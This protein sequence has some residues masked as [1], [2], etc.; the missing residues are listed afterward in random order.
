[1]TEQQTVSP[2]FPLDDEIMKYDYNTHRY[3]LTK[4]GVETELGENLD[5]ILNSTGDANPSSL[6]ARFL[7]RVSQAVYGYLYRDTMNEQWLEYILATYPPLRATV[8]DMLQA[9]LMYMLMERGYKLVSGVNV[10][11]GK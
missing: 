4:N 3:V 9:Q 11:R 2:K 1:M 10:V 5:I 7:R 8:K 6:A